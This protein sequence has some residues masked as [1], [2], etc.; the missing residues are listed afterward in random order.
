MVTVGGGVEK[1]WNAFHGRRLSVRIDWS[2]DRGDSGHA[3][4]APGHTFM[5]ARRMDLPGPPAPDRL[6]HQVEIDGST[7]VFGRLPY[8]SDPAI[9]VT[10]TERQPVLHRGQ[11]ANGAI[12]EIT[13]SAGDTTVPVPAQTISLPHATSHVVVRFPEV[14]ISITVNSDAALTDPA[15]DSGTVQVGL[16]TFEN[17]DAWLVAA[18]AVALSPEPGVVGHHELK[19]AFERWRGT[20]P[21]STGAFDRKVL[22]PALERRGIDLPG[23]RLN[24]IVYL[25]ERARATAEFSPHLLAEVRS[26]LDG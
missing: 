10:A 2:S 13:S 16:A 8:L 24:K 18:L 1:V 20:E 26:R 19:S 12:V 14:A 3:D 21:L 6:F 5:L 25:V 4:V 23:P 11:R 7:Y 9:V 22:R 17:D 15:A